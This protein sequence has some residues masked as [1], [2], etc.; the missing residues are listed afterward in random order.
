LGDLAA[1]VGLSSLLEVTVNTHAGETENGSR[2]DEL[3]IMRTF[4][5]P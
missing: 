4:E 5:Y 2:E 3:A 1:P